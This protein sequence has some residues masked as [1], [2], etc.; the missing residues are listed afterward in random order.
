MT[1][2]RNPKKVNEI[3]KKYTKNPL[4]SKEIN[5]S[6]QKSVKNQREINEICKNR[7]QTDNTMPHKALFLMILMT[8]PYLKHENKTNARPFGQGE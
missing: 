3:R 2:Q 6:L 7:K 5:E 4:N 8:K 1:F